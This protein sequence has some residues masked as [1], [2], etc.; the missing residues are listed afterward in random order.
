[1]Q[2]SDFK[3]K[4]KM[5]MKDICLDIINDE[6]NSISVKNQRIGFEKLK[7]IIETAIKLSNKKGFHA[8]SLRKLCS[9]SG[10]SMGGLYGYISSKD[11]LLEVIQSQGRRMVLKVINECL[12]ESYDLEEQLERA[13]YTHLYIS[14]MI[15]PWF[16][17]SYMESRFFTKEEQERSIKMELLT[18]QVFSDILEKGR[19]KG[20]FQLKD[21]VL[22][23]SVIKAM[24]QDWYLKR[25]KY[26]K[27][28]ISVEDY[29]NFLISFVKGFLNEK[30]NKSY[31]ISTTPP[32]SNI[33]KGSSATKR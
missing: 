15:Q 32:E 25:W 9:E 7:I 5:S 13:I 17:F 14:E 22:T 24:L 3:K 20:R 26:T 30:V 31:N 4:F 23:A 12:D 29:A 28:N 11:E 21:P 6:N 8:M 27:R 16:F 33:Q 1:M 19:L 18:E 10:L 2:F